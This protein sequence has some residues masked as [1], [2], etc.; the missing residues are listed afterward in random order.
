MLFRSH[1]L[2]GQTH[3]R[4]GQAEEALASYDR[5]IQLQPDFA[6]AHGNRANVLVIFGRFKEALAAFD[7]ALAIRPDSH[8]DWINRG[9]LLQDFELFDEALASYD[10]A[11]ALRPEFAPAHLNR[12]NVLRDLGQIAD[13][14]A[15]LNGT[16]PGT[17][18]F[19]LALA[20][21]N[22]AIALD[23]KLAD[24]FLGRALVYLLR[25][26][27]DAGFRDFE[28]RTKVGKPTFTALPHPS[29]NGEPLPGERLVLVAEQ[30]LG[31]TINFSRFAP[32]LAARGYDVTLMVRPSMRALL[33]ALHNVTIVTSPEDLAQDPRPIKWLP[34][35]SV[36]GQLG[37][38]PE[39]VP[40]DVPY[41]SASPERIASW[42]QRLGK[43]GFKIGI[44]W[45][46]GHSENLHFTRRNIPL[47]QFAPL[48]ALPSVRLFS[49]Q[50]GPAAA[51]APF[52]GF[53]NRITV[54]AT[55]PNPDADLFLDTAAVMTQLDLIITCDTSV[56]HL[57]GALARPV[58]TL[59][60]MV[61]DWRWLLG[62][63]DSPWYPTMRLFRQ[64]APGEWSDVIARIVE[65]VRAKL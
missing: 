45:V 48:A 37:I 59:L 17:S 44:N 60:P 4:L 15:N 64:S 23:A 26:K 31:D 6:D 24:S 12:A 49:L 40:A 42:G 57:A 53:G 1:N 14:R 9:A 8:E 30:G 46:S 27:W 38:Q 51:Q 7:R 50:K 61:A 25:G 20:A 36:A 55:D 34:L 32:L 65:A 58:Y 43:D 22:K 52:V 19:D 28:F 3:F 10:H 56:A 47:E 5:A 33:S 11:I 2:L 63:D 29:W 41:L 35:M 13:A 21:Y 62:R 18:S 39:T 54:L 16:P